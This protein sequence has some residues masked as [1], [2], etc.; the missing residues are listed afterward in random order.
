MSETLRP[1]LLSNGKLYCVED[2]RTEGERDECALSLEDA[3]YLSERDKAEAR[4]QL[5]RGIKRV[6]LARA[7]CGFFARIFSRKSCRAD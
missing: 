6:E 5:L 1:R 7:P 4:A 3:F 2:A